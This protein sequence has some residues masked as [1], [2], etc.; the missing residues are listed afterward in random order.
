MAVVFFVTF[1]LSPW[2][3]N[4]ARN[5]YWVEFTW[6][7]PMLIGIFIAWKV[8]RRQYRAINYLAAFIF[9]MIKCLCGYEYISVVMMGLIAFLM[10]DFVQAVVQKNKERGMLLFRTILI[11]G[12]VALMG[13]FAAI[14]IHGSLRGGSL[15][16]GIKHIFEENVLCRTYG[17]DMNKFGEAFWASFNASVWEVL[18][19][20]FKF[21]TEVITGVSGNIFPLLC[22]VPLCIF[23]IDYRRNRLDTELIA[24]YVIFFFTSISWFCLAKSHSYIHTHMNFVLWYFGFVQICFYVIVKKLIEIFNKTYWVE[25][26]EKS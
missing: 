8:E 16:E 19:E 6:F 18:C 11:M 13:F 12:L 9:I 14:C 1:W 20:Y 15:Y 3:I 23:V 4:F 25:R 7:I 17:G 2:V 5:L 26:F 24:M 21:S 10:A 22:I